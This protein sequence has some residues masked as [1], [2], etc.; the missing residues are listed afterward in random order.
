MSTINPVSKQSSEDLGDMELIHFELDNS[1]R[2]IQIYLK[3][4]VFE[5][6]F[7][8]FG[9]DANEGTW[10]NSGI[11]CYKL[12]YSESRLY[13]N[14][15]SNWNYGLFSEGYPNLSMLRSKGIK[16]GVWINITN[17]MYSEEELNK[18]KRDF[19]QYTLNFY[20]KFI[21]KYMISGVVTIPKTPKL[22]PSKAKEA[23]SLTDAEKLYLRSFNN[24]KW[25]KISESRRNTINRLFKKSSSTQL[26]A[27]FLESWGIIIN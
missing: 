9:L 12:P 19:C 13:T 18:F 6:F 3:S 25:E 11:K 17:Y 5:S 24:I 23:L 26:Y 8:Q 16:N 2:G 1:E 20:K 21:E 7:S 14:M 15:L 4:Q 22:K 10:G 27:G